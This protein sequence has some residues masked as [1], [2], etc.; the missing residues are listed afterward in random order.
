VPLTA[1]H[2]GIWH[3]R[4]IDLLPDGRCGNYENRPHGPCVLY[5][6]GSDSLCKHGISNYGMCTCGSKELKPNV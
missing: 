3:F 4:C 2:K 1:D 5:E 6:P